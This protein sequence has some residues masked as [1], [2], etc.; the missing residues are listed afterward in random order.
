MICVVF[1]V[2]L[3]GLLYFCRC[4]AYNQYTKKRA[5]RPKFPVIWK[6]IQW[7]SD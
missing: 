6:K 4:G 3:M 2:V 5:S 1:L 7:V